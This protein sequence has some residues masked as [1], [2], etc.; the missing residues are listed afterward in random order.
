MAL[1]ATGGEKRG[2]EDQGDEN[3]TVARELAVVRHHVARLSNS[4]AV[5]TTDKPRFENPLGRF[6]GRKIH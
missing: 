1:V 3:R 5:K 4:G 2:E 6:R